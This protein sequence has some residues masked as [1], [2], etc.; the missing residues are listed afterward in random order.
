[1]ACR[2]AAYNAL[3]EMSEYL[4]KQA[5]HADV[6]RAKLEDEQ[7]KIWTPF[8]VLE[9]CCIPWLSDGSEVAGHRSNHNVTLGCSGGCGKSHPRI[10]LEF[11]EVSG[12]TAH[13]SHRLEPFVRHFEELCEAGLAS[14]IST[15]PRSKVNAASKSG[16]MSYSLKGFLLEHGDK[17]QRSSRFGYHLVKVTP[18][19]LAASRRAHQRQVEKEEEEKE[20]QAKRQRVALERRGFHFDGRNLLDRALQVCHDHGA[21]LDHLDLLEI[22]W[23]RLSGHRTLAKVAAKLAAKRMQGI[24][25]NYSASLLGVPTGGPEVRFFSLPGFKEASQGPYTLKQSKERVGRF[26]PE[27][28]GQEIAWENS[29][30][31]DKLPRDLLTFSL[32]FTV[33]LQEAISATNAFPNPHVFPEQDCIFSHPLEVGRYHIDL[34]IDFEDEN[35]PEGLHQA[36]CQQTPCSKMMVQVSTGGLNYRRGSLRLQ[37]LDFE[38][39]HLLGIYARKKLVLAKQR[40]TETKQ[41][42]PITKSEKDYV[43]AIADMVRKAPGTGE[44]TFEGLDGW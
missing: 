44:R 10:T 13:L 8:E 35:V 3:T 28:H 26:F 5:V 7:R 30:A 22:A 34:P 40:L 20:R 2:K 39:C 9:S 18:S 43:K 11:D 27:T 4:E 42:R 36:H 19:A 15:E 12:S 21:F 29:N 37:S 16:S 25:L 24:R 33:V 6:A 23:M 17:L 1:M 38:F 41:K 14:R 32:R 31:D